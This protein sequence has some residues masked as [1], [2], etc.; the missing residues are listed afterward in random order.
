MDNLQTSR[1]NMAEMSGGLPPRLQRLL[2]AGLFTPRVGRLGSAQSQQFMPG[3]PLS[4]QAGGGHSIHHVYAERVPLAVGWEGLGAWM[5][6][7]LTGG[8]P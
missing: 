4:T 1:V 8:L 5:C 6:L 2:N 3:L 7:A